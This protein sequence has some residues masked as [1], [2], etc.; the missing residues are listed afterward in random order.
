MKENIKDADELPL[1]KT[2]DE[3]KTREFNFKNSPDVHQVGLIAQELQD[4]APDSLKECFVTTNENSG[5]LA[6]N[7]NKLIYLCIAKIHQ[8]EKEIEELKTK[9]R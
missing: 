8:L 6:I 4:A 2:F 7:E 3:L 5:Y 9:T 1:I